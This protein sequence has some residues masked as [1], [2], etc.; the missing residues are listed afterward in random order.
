MTLAEMFKTIVINHAQIDNYSTFKTY[1]FGL[2]DTCGT[3]VT[4]QNANDT[5]TARF[6]DGSVLIFEYSDEHCYVSFK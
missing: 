1:W 4:N 5:Y 6:N 3:V 2:M